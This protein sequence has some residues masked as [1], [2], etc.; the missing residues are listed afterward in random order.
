MVIVVFGRASFARPS[1]EPLDAVADW[2]KAD[3]PAATNSAAASPANLFR[4]E[5]FMGNLLIFQF[6]RDSLGRTGI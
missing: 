3:V 6:D 1:Q 2:Q 5:S 4:Y